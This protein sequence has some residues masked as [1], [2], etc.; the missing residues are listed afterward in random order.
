MNWVDWCWGISGYNWLMDWDS[1]VWSWS[2]GSMAFI[3]NFG[4]VTGI[5]VSGVVSYSLGTA[6]GEENVIRAGGN[7]VVPVFFSAK[8]DS[9]VIIDNLVSIVVVSRFAVLGFMVGRGGFIGWGI[10]SNG[11]SHDSEKSN[12]DLHV[13]GL[14]V[15]IQMML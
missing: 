6:I 13:V 15:V 3:G 12:E 11:D 5:S 1:L 14:V 10:V 9:R 2:I 4:N 8:V 7:L